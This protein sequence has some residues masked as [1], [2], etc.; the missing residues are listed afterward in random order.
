MSVS[1]FSLDESWSLDDDDES[2]EA[3]EGSSL[4]TSSVASP[5][6]PGKQSLLL[7]AKKN[8]AGKAANSGVGRALFK[9]FADEETVHLLAIFRAMVTRYSDEKTGKAMQKNVVKIFVK[10]LILYEDKILTEENFQEIYGLFRKMCALLK[11]SFLNLKAN[12]QTGSELDEATNQRIVARLKEMHSS[13]HVLLSPRLT[14]SSLTRM[15]EI[16][17]LMATEKFIKF[18]FADQDLENM[19]KIFAYYLNHY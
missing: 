19:V 8:I 11:N 17:A 15:N 3:P 5:S 1:E 18:I 4:T 10:V 14:S 12:N 16:F 7:R 13:L 2:V 9:K 6:V